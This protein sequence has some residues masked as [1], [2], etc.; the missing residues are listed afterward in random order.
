MTDDDLTDLR[1]RSARSDRDAIDQLVELAGNA[2][3]L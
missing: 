2:V 3:T 1:T